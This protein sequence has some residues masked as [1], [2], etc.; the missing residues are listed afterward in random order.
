VPPRKAPD[1]KKF[2]SEVYG[3]WKIAFSKGL[4]ND[5]TFRAMAENPREKPIYVQGS[6]T[7]DVIAKAKAEIDA[8][9]QET[10]DMGTEGQ[11]LDLNS[12]FTNEIFENGTNVLPIRLYK[13]DGHLMLEVIS[14]EWF[15]AI[16]GDETLAKNGY[17]MPKT[18]MSSGMK[19]TAGS[20]H[21]YAV[22]ISPKEIQTL[23]LRRN[24]RYVVQEL[25]SNEYG[26]QFKVIYDSTTASPTDK[27]K[28][29]KPGFTVGA[30][31]KGK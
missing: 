4:M 28:L 6:S 14:P 30:W 22:R 1:K 26:R 17:K 15:D 29:G 2:G 20:T 21:M 31:S 24:G 23:G 8:K 19:T 16:E 9:A 18:R 7:E 11:V 13:E 3:T 27:Q 10:G 5:G 25:G 12:N